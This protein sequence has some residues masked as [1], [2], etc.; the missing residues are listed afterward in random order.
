[1]R[2]IRQQVRPRSSR[3][4]RI[5]RATC[6]PHSAEWAS[7][8]AYAV[9]LIENAADLTC[10]R[11]QH[12]F[13]VARTFV[14]QPQQGARSDGLGETTGP[15]NEGGPIYEGGPKRA[16]RAETHRRSSPTSS[17]SRWI[18]RLRSSAPSEVEGSIPPLLNMTPISSLRR[19]RTCTQ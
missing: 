3:D 19:H 2:R 8:G 4:R 15:M 9:F 14:A 16:C 17:S 5:G 12:P 13:R 11:A 6:P 18:R 7:L 1:L 10:L